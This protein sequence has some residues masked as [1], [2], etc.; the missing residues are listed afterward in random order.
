MVLTLD[1]L[2]AMGFDYYAS[3]PVLIPPQNHLPFSDPPAHKYVSRYPKP[4]SLNYLARATDAIAGR[5]RGRAN[6][7][8]DAELDDELEASSRPI[9]SHA[10]VRPEPVMGPGMTL[11][12][13]DA[14]ALNISPE[15]QSGTW[16]EEQAASAAAD[17]PKLAARKSQRRI[18]D[19]TEDRDAIDPIVRALGI[20]W[21]R[22]SDDDPGIRGSETFVRKHFA[23]V[24]PR[25]LLHHEGLA[26]YVVRSEPRSAQGYWRQWWLF[27]EDLRGARFL[28]NDDADLFRR[29]GNKRRDACGGCWIPDILC[30]GPE[31]LPSDPMGSSFGNA[32]S[33]AVEQ[34]PVPVEMAV[35]D[36]VMEE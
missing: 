16:M 26:V 33:T 8:D 18:S 24:A 6:C 29:L 32:S 13:P 23:L 19:P 12:Y 17:R 21:R 27:R 28:C 30:E 1:G 22:L 15:S 7:D 10:N 5:K 14:P 34:T 36:V 3:S 2:N 35:Q 4:P 25:I 11:V 9:S 31:L 20:G